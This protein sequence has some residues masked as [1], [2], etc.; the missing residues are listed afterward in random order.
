MHPVI[1]S[2]GMAVVLCATAGAQSADSKAQPL[3]QSPPTFC[4][5]VA[6]PAKC[7]HSPRTTR[8]GKHVAVRAQDARLLAPSTTIEEQL[9]L[10]FTMKTTA[11]PAGGIVSLCDGLM[12]L[13]AALTQLLLV[14]ICLAVG[15]R[16]MWKGIL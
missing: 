13:V 1:W 9:S 15:S 6:S 4:P 8:A 10:Q 16:T 3:T 5:T 11:T 14:V 12:I 7:S 2:L